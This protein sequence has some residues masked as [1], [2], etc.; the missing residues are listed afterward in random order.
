VA[1]IEPAEEMRISVTDHCA[2]LWAERTGLGRSGLEHCLYDPER[3]SAA[4]PPRWTGLS[5]SPEHRYLLTIEG[6]VCFEL[7]PTELSG[8][9]YA[10]INCVV[11]NR[12]ALARRLPA[13]PPR[14]RWPVL[15]GIVGAV[16]VLGAIGVGTYVL[17][18]DSGGGSSA[19]SSEATR[20]RPSASLLRASFVADRLRRRGLKHRR[21][22]LVRRRM[23]LLPREVCASLV[24]RGGR[25]AGRYCV[26]TIGGAV[27]GSWRVARGRPDRPRYRAGF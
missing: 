13:Q 6:E 5:P 8:Y 23:P 14:R 20:A 25:P 21:A 4:R 11:R 17:V 3:V 1:A 7:A 18:R 2:Q 15:L 19:T 27:V 16:V 12:S 26:A 24:R 9:D 22:R 10:A